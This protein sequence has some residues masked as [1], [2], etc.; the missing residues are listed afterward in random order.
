MELRFIGNGFDTITMKSCD[1]SV[2]SKLPKQLKYS[3]NL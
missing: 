2:R 1:K 3:V